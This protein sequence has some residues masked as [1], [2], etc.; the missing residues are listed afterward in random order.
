M[1]E[2]HLKTKIQAILAANPLIQQV[3]NYEAA[4]FSG[5]P[6]VT[7]VAQGNDG[8]WRS[9]TQNKRPYDFLVRVWV[10]RGETRNDQQAEDV[11]TDVV[12]SILDDFDKFYTLGTGSPGAAL[13]LPTGYTMVRVEALKGERLYAER[14]TT[15]RV[16]D[17]TVRCI[18][19][20]DVTLI[21]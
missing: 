2:S 6:A 5:D 10:K 20:V 16:A 21:S 9:T 7:I 14:E 8:E 15:Y 19:D 18:M 17:I 12:S 4:E 13:V 3:Y 11:M 1:V